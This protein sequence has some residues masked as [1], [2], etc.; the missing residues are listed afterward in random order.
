MSISLFDVTGPVMIGP[1]SSHTAG[2]AKLSRMAALLC[3]GAFEKVTFGLH[4]SFARTYLGHGTDRALA[5]GAL[6]L[7]EW[8]DRLRHAF[9][10]ARRRGVVCEFY[11]TVLQD[12]HENSVLMTFYR[13]DGTQCQVEGCSL[14]GGRVCIRKL[15]GF[16]VELYCERPTVMVLHGDVPGILGRITACAADHGLNIALLRSTRRKRGD[17]ACCIIETDEQVGQD[18]RRSMEQIPCVLRVEV[19]DPMSGGAV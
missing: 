1:S 12:A 10:I 2:A 4:G 9:D 11:E 8:D 15:D 19:I 16:D 5:A 14:G 17:V 3:G 13:K 7:P 6:G 18:L